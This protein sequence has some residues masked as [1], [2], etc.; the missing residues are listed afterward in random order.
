MPGAVTVTW[1][2]ISHYA[3]ASSHDS[4]TASVGLCAASASSVMR[5]PPRILGYVTYFPKRLPPCCRFS[6]KM[7]FLLLKVRS[8]S[9]MHSAICKGCSSVGSSEVQKGLKSEV[10]KNAQRHQL[11][12]VQFLRVLGCKSASSGGFVFQNCGFGD[13]PL[14][15]IPYRERPPDVA[16]RQAPAGARGCSEVQK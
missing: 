3:K 8:N 13:R 9:D 7:S 6:A 5:H 1:H 14:C 11:G 16:Y 10:Q 12:E 15:T 4:E 2:A